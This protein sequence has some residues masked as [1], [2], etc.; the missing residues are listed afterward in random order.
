MYIV[1]I[2]ML[3]YELSY[4]GC[5][6]KH[7]SLAKFIKDLS[8]LVKRSTY[9]NIKSLEMYFFILLIHKRTTFFLKKDCLF[10]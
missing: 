9:F 5:V 10:A 2:Y 6:S 3:Q 1:Q 8:A 7:H 4:R